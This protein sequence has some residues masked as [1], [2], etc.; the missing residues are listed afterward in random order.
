MGSFEILRSCATIARVDYADSAY[1]L[2]RELQ[3]APSHA[4]S[5][6]QSDSSSCYGCQYLMQSRWAP[7][8]HKAHAPLLAVKECPCPRVRSFYDPADVMD[9]VQ[10]CK[11]AVE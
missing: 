4:S 5:C 9:L 3:G 10:R 2:T 8:C 7:W 11:E 1:A 6:S